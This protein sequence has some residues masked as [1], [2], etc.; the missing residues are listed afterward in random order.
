MRENGGKFKNSKIILDLL[1]SIIKC[2]F[3]GILFFL[4]LEFLRI[5]KF[6]RKIVRSTWANNKNG[7]KFK[8]YF[9]YIGFCKTKCISFGIFFFLFVEFLRIQEF[10]DYSFDMR[11][12]LFWTICWISYCKTKCNTRWEVLRSAATPTNINF[13]YEYFGNRYT[14]I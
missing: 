5:Q 10:K 4:F 11:E 6:K 12:K 7:G 2:I 13:T 14:C 9:G 3:F 8:N 1:V